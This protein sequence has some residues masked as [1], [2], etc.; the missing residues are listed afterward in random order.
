MVIPRLDLI[1]SFMGSVSSSALALILPP[2][3]EITTFYPEDM[4]YGTIAKD[5]MISILGLLGCVFGTYQ[6]LCELIQP[7]NP[8]I[9]NSTGVYA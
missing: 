3:L 9:V 4:S 5:I 7:I 6:A 2:L 1:I 8:F